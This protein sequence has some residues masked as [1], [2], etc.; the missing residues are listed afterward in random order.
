M[1][2]DTAMVLA[3]GL[4]TRIR[5]LDPETPKPLI[6]VAGMALIDYSFEM[7]ADGGVRKAVVNVHHRADQLEAHLAGV[8]RPEIAVSDERERLL[9]TGGGILK[10]LPMLGKDPFFCTNT[11]AILLGGSENPASFLRR[12]WTEDCDALLLMVPLS[13]TSGYQGQGDFSLTPEGLIADRSEGAPLV[14]T[15]LQI[16]RP[17]LFDGAEVEPVSTRAFWE[18]ARAAGR[19]RGV[20]FDGRW[21]HVGDPEGHRLAEERLGK[22]VN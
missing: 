17:A 19:M 20:L 14:F 21:M 10:A 13:E 8:E 15:G 16:L 1:N 4:G 11:D 9:E 18:K 5:S 7:L 2:I 22:E 12:Q 6:K 3:A